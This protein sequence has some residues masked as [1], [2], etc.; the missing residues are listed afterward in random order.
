M[1]KKDTLFYAIEF[2]GEYGGDKIQKAIETALKEKG[3]N[4]KIIVVSSEGP[5]RGKW[6]LRNLI[7]IPSNTTLLLEDCY[8]FLKDNAKDN[9]ITNVG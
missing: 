2:D 8:I 7:K 4:K 9:L 6:V 5:D 3:D 1:G